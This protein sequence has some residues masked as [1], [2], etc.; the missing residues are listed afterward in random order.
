M[1]FYLQIALKRSMYQIS[2]TYCYWEVKNV[3]KNCIFLQRIFYKQ[4]SLLKLCTNKNFW[5]VI[6][7]SV[8]VLIV[9]IKYHFQKHIHIFQMDENK[10]K[11]NTSWQSS[12]SFL[13]NDTNFLSVS[14]KLTKIWSWQKKF[15]KVRRFFCPQRIKF[16]KISFSWFFLELIPWKYKTIKNCRWFK[17]F[18][19][20]F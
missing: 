10:N 1:L 8:L 9:N 17:I 19:L 13:S 6:Q 5:N 3:T 18:K 7:G 11:P 4:S 20:W 2:K 15:Q 16:I 12:T 14:Q